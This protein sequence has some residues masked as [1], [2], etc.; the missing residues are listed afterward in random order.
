MLN[1]CKQTEHNRHKQFQRD[2]IMKGHCLGR[3]KQ[4]DEMNYTSER[5]TCRTKYLEHS[6]SK[7]EMGKILRQ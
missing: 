2:H 1:K 5:K 7:Q 6:F 3:E 4:S